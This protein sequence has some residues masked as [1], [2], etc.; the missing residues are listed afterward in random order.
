MEVIVCSIYDVF[1]FFQK[2]YLCVCV[3]IQLEVYVSEYAL[4]RYI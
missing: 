4:E 2:L 1:V 3:Y